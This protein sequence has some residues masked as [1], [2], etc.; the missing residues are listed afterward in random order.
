MYPIIL[1][2][3]TL[4]Q[5][6]QTLKEKTIQFKTLLETGADYPKLQKIYRELKKLQ[7][8]IVQ[9]ETIGEDLF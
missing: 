2:K 9:R 4:S 7:Y 1:A 8:E 5:L 6:K 3:V